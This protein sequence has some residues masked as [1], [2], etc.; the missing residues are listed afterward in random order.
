VIPPVIFHG[1]RSGEKSPRHGRPDH[2]LWIVTRANPLYWDGQLTDWTACFDTHSLTALG[3]WPGLRDSASRHQTLDWYAREPRGGRPI[4]MHTATDEV[5][6]SVTYPLR[7]VQIGIP[8]DEG[9]SW[10]PNRMFGCMADFLFGLAV[11][12]QRPRI[13]LNGVGMSHEAG[14][15]YLHRSVLYWI[16]YCRGLG[17]EVFVEG[18]SIYRNAERQLYAYER[19][20][21]EELDALMA[22]FSVKSKPDNDLAALQTLVDEWRVTARSSTQCANELD[23]VLAVLQRLKDQPPI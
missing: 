1:K 16:G 17:I 9:N 19:Y 12:E 14:H 22:T 11:L 2:D 8:I 5:P 23:H 7:D 4:Y 13:V 15:Q 3:R 6:A 18:D 10:Q 21:Y 20:G